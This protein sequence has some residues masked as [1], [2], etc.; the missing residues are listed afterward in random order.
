[1]FGWVWLVFLSLFAEI[2]NYCSASN[3][4]SKDDRTIEQKTHLILANTYKQIV[5]NQYGRRGLNHL[6]KAYQRSC[7]SLGGLCCCKLNL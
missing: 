3:T 7:T 2:K 6:L 4:K 1:M 5:E